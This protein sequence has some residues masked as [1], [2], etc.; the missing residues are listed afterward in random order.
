MFEKMR[1]VKDVSGNILNFCTNNVNLDFPLLIQ[2]P[3]F[4]TD[5]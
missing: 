2:K 3:I 4:S 5:V 1:L